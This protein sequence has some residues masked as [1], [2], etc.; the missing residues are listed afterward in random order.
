M[1]PT[2]EDWRESEIGL[3]GNEEREDGKGEEEV[4]RRLGVVGGGGWP[5]GRCRQ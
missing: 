1:T 3:E 4:K 5:W 2:S